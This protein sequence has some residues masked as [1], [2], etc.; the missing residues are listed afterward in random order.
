VRSL[1]DLGAKDL[2]QLGK[3]RVLAPRSLHQASEPTMRESD[4]APRVGSGS[5]LL[6]N[7][8]PLCSRSRAGARLRAGRG[9]SGR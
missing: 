4:I 9:S 5:Q 7:V 6:G 2:R 8:H 1:S 3:R